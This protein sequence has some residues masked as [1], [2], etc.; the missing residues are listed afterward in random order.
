MTNTSDR[1]MRRRLPAVLIL[2][3]LV[4]PGIALHL[5]RSA[6]EEAHPIPTPAA[7]EKPGAASSEG[8]GLRR[9]LFLERPGRLPACQGCHNAVSRY[10]G[11]ERS[12]ARHEDLS[13][14][15]TGRGAAARYRMYRDGAAP[16]SC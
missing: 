8:R 1:P 5:S 15:A 12:T 3:A 14:G 4:P 10:A 6:A 16:D 2:A 13:T 11:G 7:D 9:Q